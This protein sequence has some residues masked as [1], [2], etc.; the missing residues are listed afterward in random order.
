M[1][2]LAAP[3][4]FLA[5]VA[6]ALL[7]LLV[8]A[9]VG[10][11]A[12]FVFGGRPEWLTSDPGATEGTMSAQIAEAVTPQI[13]EASIREHLSHLTGASPAPLEGGALT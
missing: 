10:A 12:G 3:L 7:V 2:G 8:A 13:D 1:R 6:G 9:G 5:Y 11:T 4:R